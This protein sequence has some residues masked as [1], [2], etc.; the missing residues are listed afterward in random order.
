EILRGNLCGM[1]PTSC[2]DQFSKAIDE[3]LAS[4]Q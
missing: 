4:A 2:A 3:A 1:K